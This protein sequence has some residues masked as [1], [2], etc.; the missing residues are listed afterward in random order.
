MPPTK[1]PAVPLLDLSRIPHP[2][3]DQ[4]LPKLET[5][6]KGS[7]SIGLSDDSSSDIVSSEDHYHSDGAA[8]EAL[9]DAGSDCANTELHSSLHVS[10]EHRIRVG[11][12]SGVKLGYRPWR[13]VSFTAIYLIAMAATVASSLVTQPGSL[14]LQAILSANA[15]DVYYLY[16]HRAV[17]A[18]KSSAGVFMIMT[19]VS[20]GIGIFWLHLL[21]QHTKTM[22]Y[23]TIVLS[24]VLCSIVGLV[25]VL[26]SYVAFIM[27][28]LI[29][30][31]SN[32]WSHTI[33]YFF[34]NCSC[35]ILYTSSCTSGHYR[36][37]SNE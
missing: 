25:L 4:P 11:E 31:Q 15:S 27:V 14:D 29:C 17:A 26:H 22:V 37:G 7:D 32:H 36:V 5:L 19:L 28:S 6:H 16:L 35:C 8:S 1:P 21:Q 18:F 13:D 20:T 9:S 33:C 34:V 10:G 3:S 12:L 24:P 2:P 23:L 30:I